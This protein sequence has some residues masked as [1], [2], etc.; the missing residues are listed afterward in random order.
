M[1]ERENANQVSLLYRGLL[2]NS[3]NSRELEKEK[4]EINEEFRPG[5][6]KKKEYIVTN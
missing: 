2:D 6:R 3:I 5:K 4:Y 1:V